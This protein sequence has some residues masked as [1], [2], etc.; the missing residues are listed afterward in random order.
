MKHVDQRKG[1]EKQS[2]SNVEGNQDDNI[3][4]FTLVDKFVY[5]HVVSCLAE[6]AF[7]EVML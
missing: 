4:H 5:Q 6:K 3:P 1:K 2:E 7:Q